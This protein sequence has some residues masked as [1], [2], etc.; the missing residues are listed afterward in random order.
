MLFVVAFLELL[1]VILSGTKHR[2]SQQGDFA[3]NTVK[4][5]KMGCVGDNSTTQTTRKTTHNTSSCSWS[6]RP[7]SFPVFLYSMRQEAEEE[8]G[9]EASLEKVSK[10]TSESLKNT[11]TDEDHIGQNVCIKICTEI[12]SDYH[13][14]Y[15]LWRV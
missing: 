9:N 5:L 7:G 10:W 1:P 4:R 15:V 8:P 6:D 14:Y 12:R 3:S 11:I 13:P 2:D